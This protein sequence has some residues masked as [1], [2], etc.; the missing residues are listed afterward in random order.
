MAKRYYSRRKSSDTSQVFIVLLIIL[1][2]AG[3]VTKYISSFTLDILSLVFILGVFII[4]IGLSVLFYLSRKDKRRRRALTLSHVDQMTGV[5][6]EQYLGD[7]LKSQGYS[8][9]F[10]PLSGDF[11]TDIIA[12]K[13]HIKYSIQAKRY[14]ER[15]GPPAIQQAVAA[16]KVYKCDKAIVITNSFFTKEAKELAKYNDCTLIDREELTDWIFKFQNSKVKVIG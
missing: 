3:L 4:I 11:G 10:T 12:E 16:L 1:G 8:V 9:K 2:L 5:E 7:L 14:K 6:F 13:E 15:V